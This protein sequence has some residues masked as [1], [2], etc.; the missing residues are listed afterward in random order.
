MNSGGNMKKASIYYFIGT[1]FNKGIVFL[2]V[3]I[4]TR[5]L[6]VSDYGIVTTY[7]SWVGI[8]SMFMSLALYM[9]I[10]LS[11]VDYENNVYDFLSTILLFTMGYGAAITFMVMIVAYIIPLSI[12]L[13][14][15]LL[16]LLHSIGSALIED[17][18]Q[19]LLMKVKYRL[20]T[21]IMIIPNLL[22]TIIAVTIIR[23][24]LNN[25]LYW[26]RIIPTALITFFVGFCLALY[27]L[28][29]GKIVIN[30][31]YLLYGVK[32]SLPLVLH[33][34]ALNILSQSDRTMIT[35][36][37]NSTETGIYGLIYNFSMIATVITTAFDGIWVPFFT[38]NMKKNS[39]KEI[40][41]FSIKYIELMTIAM[42]GVVLIGPEVV[43][44]LATEA[45]WEGIS[46]IP[47]IVLSNYLI[48]VYTLY[49]YIEHFYKKTV[50]ISINTSIAA[51]INILLNYFFIIQ[52]GYVGAA[53]A[54][55]I[56]YSVSLVLHF[57]YARTLNKEVLP[58]L[59]IL[60]PL[61][62]LVGVVAAFYLFI[63]AWLVRWIL[64][65]MCVI[66]LF[67]KERAFVVS[68][69]KNK[70]I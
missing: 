43:K 64:A 68:I 22:S 45:Y 5:I 16:C 9:S 48:F 50:F 63:N 66:I 51:T 36:L 52:W 17:I 6:T 60:V 35:W 40:N 26:G 37:K 19:F 20:R 30:R 29:K 2:T 38:N 1:L 39:Y 3:P 31:E 8:I 54:T 25:E 11:F 61:I 42:I 27:F 56:S 62:I 55:L 13:G 23:Y 12:N 67:I 47:P 18:S 28:P 24:V 15:I 33:G 21:I 46:I 53:F 4:F 44:V 57:I 10:R 69:I 41:S 7:N 14:I 65:F 34:I 32:I 58:L 49:V 59:P 70:R